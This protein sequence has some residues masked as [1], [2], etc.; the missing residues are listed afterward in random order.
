MPHFSET[1][2]SLLVLL[3]NVNELIVKAS[4]RR[5]SSD[6]MR[7]FKIYANNVNFPIPE[8]KV[9]NFHAILI[10]AKPFTLTHLIK[11]IADDVAM[12]DHRKA[13]GNLKLKK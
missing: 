3:N 7:A 4:D 11:D 13:V 2:K 6:V 12:Q 5:N 9:S 1:A 8:D 10:D